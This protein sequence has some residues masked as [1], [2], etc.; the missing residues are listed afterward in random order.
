MSTYTIYFSST[1]GTE[2]IV[3]T[4]ANEFGNY[5]EID[6]SNR[7]IE[8]NQTFTEDDICIIGV[9]SYGGRVPDIALQRMN[10]YKGNKTKTILVVSYGNR[11][12][13]DTLREL[14]Q[15]LTARGF[16]CIAA[17]SAIAEHSIMRQFAIGRPDEKDKKQLIKF[18]NQILNKINQSIDYKFLKL[19]GN[20]PY[21]QYNGVALKPK[22][23]GKCIECRLCAKMCPVGA[24]SI[25]DLRK[26]NNDLCISCMRCVNICPTKAR[27]VSSLKLKLASKKMKKTCSQHKENELFI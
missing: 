25:T 12:Y 7:E 22:T 4:I 10:N 27:T 11:A 15:H 18:S 8:L 24:I 5:N 19:P 2:T 17:I 1:K 13:E 21:K 6:L 14:Q 3:K 20:S 9:P 26:T 23:S 16:Y